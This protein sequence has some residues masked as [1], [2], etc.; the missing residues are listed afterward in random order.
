[1]ILDR[2]NPLAQRLVVSSTVILIIF[3][4]IYNSFT[5]LLSPLIPLVTA[6]ITSLALREYYEIGR[7]KGL[8][9]REKVG[10]TLTIIYIIAIFLSSQ[11]TFL[12]SLPLLALG[13]TLIAVFSAYFFRGKNPFVNVAITLF[14]ILY[15]TIPLSCTIQINYFFPAEGLQDGRWWLFYLLAV[16]YITDSSALFIGRAMGRNKLAPVISPK[17]T[18]EGAYGGFLVAIMTSLTFYYFANFS[19]Y[20]IPI[21]LNLM[22]SIVLGSCISILAQFGD[23]AE[24]LLKRDVGVK[25]S[26]KIPGLGGMLDV[27]DSLVFTAPLLYLYLNFQNS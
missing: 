9:P 26:S 15:L 23:L 24:S 21:Q 18:W 8:E 19:T 25:D 1:M 20:R 14:G 22:Q 10:V 4:A 3:A 7:V 6:I 17:K 16:T 5:P 12:D 27:V 13:V 2:M 11:T